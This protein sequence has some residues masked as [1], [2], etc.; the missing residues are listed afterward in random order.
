MYN[1]KSKQKQTGPIRAIQSLQRKDKRKKIGTRKKEGEEEEEE[2]E[3]ELLDSWA[4][5]VVVA[6]GKSWAHL[7]VRASGR[8]GVC[9]MEA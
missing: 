6:V 2:E 1:R 9:F 3:S 4:P 7:H 8:I 5:W